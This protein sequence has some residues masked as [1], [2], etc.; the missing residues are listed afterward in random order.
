MNLDK[1]AHLELK[2]RQVLRVKKVNRENQ[3]MLD[4]QVQRESREMWE[5]PETL[6]IR[7]C[8]VRMVWL[9][10]KV[11]QVRRVQEDRMDPKETKVLKV[12]KEPEA[13]MVPLER[14]VFRE[15]MVRL[16]KWE[17]LDHLD[18]RVKPDFKEKLEQ[19]D[20]RED[21]A[22]WVHLVSKD[23]LVQLA[24]LEN[25]ASLVFPEWM[26]QKG[27]WERREREDPREKEE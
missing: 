20:P 18:L 16:R 15:K 12:Q 8:Q 14:P 23:Q 9:G 1:M 25:P 6:V 27:K 26:V 2:E 19:L 4:C 7:D 10:H 22:H 13:T 11:I 3:V 17:N 5:D 21:P 24:N